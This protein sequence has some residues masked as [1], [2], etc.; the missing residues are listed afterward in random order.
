MMD[1]RVNQRAIGILLGSS[2]GFIGVYMLATGFVRILTGS[3]VTTVNV[4]SGRVYG[5]LVVLGALW[6]LATVGTPWR[7][8]RGR[9]A[10]IYCAVLWLLAIAQAWPAKAW[11]SI[12]GAVCFVAIL[13]IEVSSNE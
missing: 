10:A 5:M 12:I 3:N 8:P 7:G 13:A 11:V 4:F 1:D 9:A 2:R 6:L